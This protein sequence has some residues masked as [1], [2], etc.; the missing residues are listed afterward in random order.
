M[1]YA[2]AMTATD[3]DPPPYLRARL[4]L[5][6]ER[7]IPALWPP[8]AALA[9]FCVL[10]GLAPTGVLPVWLRWLLTLGFVIGF[11]ALS[12]R[13]ARAIHWPDE[14]AARRRIELANGLA[15]RPLETLTDQPANADPLSQ[16]LWR[17]HVARV[18][19]RLD[20]L[21]VGPPRDLMP[22]RD[23]LALRSLVIVGLVVTAA[24]A[25]AE[26]PER[27]AALIWPTAPEI[28]VPTRLDVWITPRAYTGEAPIFASSLPAG[29]ALTIPAGSEILAQAGGFDRAPTLLIDAATT[30]FEKLG[31]DSARATAKITSGGRIA[32]MTA[33]RELAAWP[34]TVVPDN[35]PT[36][37]FASPPTAT[38]RA[39]T[40][41]EYEALDDYGVESVSAVLRRPGAEDGARTI[42]LDLAK[43]IRRKRTRA[44]SI[45]DL[46]A[47]A[48]AGQ[49]VEIQ[50]SARD[51]VGQIGRSDWVSLSLPEREFHDPVAR[52]IIAQ[53]KILMAS[54]ERAEEVAAA[55]AAI[56]SDP[57]A[58]AGDVVVF[59]ALT[60]SEAR[61]SLKERDE[62]VAPVAA[63]LWDTAI[64]IEQGDAGPRERELRAAEQALR[65]T[66]ASDPTD[67]DLARAMEAFQQALD[68]YLDALARQALQ[69][70][71][72]QTPRALPR[73]AKR[74]ERSEIQKM[75]DQARQLARSGQKEAAQAMLDKLRELMENLTAAVDSPDES[76]QQ[77]SDDSPDATQ[78]AMTKL[79]D[80]ARR[81]RDLMDRSFRRGQRGQP[82]PGGQPQDGASDEEMAAE[83]GRLREELGEMMRQLGEDGE[84]PGALGRAER[85]M[86]GAEQSLGGGSPGRAVG[87][88][89]DALAQ[90]R[91]GAK[92][93][94]ERDAQGREDGQG[95]GQGRRDGRRPNRSR[96]EGRDPLGRDGHAPNR[97]TTDLIKPADQLQRGR[98]IFDEL[99][100]RAADPS[101]PR[102][103]QDYIDR[104]LRRF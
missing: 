89:G 56:A 78:Q 44:V 37:A 57:G 34:I 5:F 102:F 13:A 91:E 95:D 97:E 101:R 63:L 86:R 74:I 81:Q 46:T 30:P 49:T 64:R 15:H 35:P 2:R 41:I 82:Q 104:L 3:F 53:R 60:T 79:Q 71:P 42:T 80:L 36:I 61:L 27:M 65:D 1:R 4:T 77:A 87:Q 67:A 38:A 73:D 50:L 90:L 31:A 25:G 70:R 85:A 83:Q 26:W 100:R 93:L 22:M 52:A 48:W 33:G 7:A 94:A 6:W 55:L 98:D 68:R 47:D 72:G 39:A 96:V 75:L 9:A 45:Q 24:L 88:Q 62:G 59:L 92:A 16:A 23:P 21:K 43:A 28:V 69:P 19:R 40:R 10:G 18:A 11:A 32:V 84:I 20:G 54:P 29:Q 103:E 66:L 58:F 14:E 99:R 17:A 8:F 76:D 51:G 12:R